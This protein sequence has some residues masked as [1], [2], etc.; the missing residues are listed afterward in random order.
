SKSKVVERGPQVENTIPQYDAQPV[1]DLANASNAESS[2]LAVTADGL[3]RGFRVWL[4]NDSVGFSFDPRVG[5]LLEAVEVFVCPPEFEIE[6]TD[7]AHRKSLFTPPQIG[8]GV[9]SMGY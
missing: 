6:A 2:R 4:I 8:F 3:W 9:L 1:W 7:G 5:L